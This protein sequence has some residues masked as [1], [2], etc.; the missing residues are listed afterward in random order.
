MKLYELSKGDR[1]K[2]KESVLVPPDA[3]TEETIEGKIL[4][5][6]KIDGAYAQV[7][8]EDEEL[9]E[10]MSNAFSDGCPFFCI[11]AGTEV[12]GVE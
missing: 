4:K 7:V 2:L 1:F 5:F 10:D 8:A 12:E 11:S 3:G 6:I 9:N